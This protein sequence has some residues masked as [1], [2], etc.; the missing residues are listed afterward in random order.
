V[1]RCHR[2]Q[3]GRT[4]I[5]RDRICRCPRGDLGEDG[6]PRAQSL[7][8]KLTKDRTPREDEPREVTAVDR[9]RSRLLGDTELLAKAIHE[10]FV[11]RRT[12]ER[13]L[14]ADDPAL[15]DWEELA[16]SLRE[17]NRDQATDITRKLASVGCEAVLSQDGRSETT[18]LEP[19]EIEMLARAEHDRWIEDRL[20]QGWRFGLRRDVAAKLSPY[21][22]AWEELAEGVRDLDRDSV[23]AIP[24]LLA[25]SGLKI[26]RRPREPE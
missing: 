7:G 12:F 22:V 1:G 16:E 25:E 10:D 5:K 2:V 21:L 3:R 15:L 9:G 13:S 26:V 24:H 23:R 17:S 20:R 8:R 6:Y 11:R 19:E 14:P 18:E 4:V